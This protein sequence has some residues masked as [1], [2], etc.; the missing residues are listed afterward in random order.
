[1]NTRPPRRASPRS[2][3]FAAALL[4]LAGCGGVADADR[5]YEQ[6]QYAQAIDAYQAVYDEHRRDPQVNYRVG[7]SFYAMA[8][9]DKA[10]KFLR[11][12][13]EAGAKERDV[14]WRLAECQD[15]QKMYF[16]ASKTF[17]RILE[18]DPRSTAALNNLAVMQIQLDDYATAQGNLEKALSISPEDA[19]ALFNLGLVYERHHRDPEKAADYFARFRA[20][21]PDAAQA[22]EVR[23]WLRRYE[24]ERTAKRAASRPRPPDPVAVSPVDAPEP[25]ET[26]DPLDAVTAR[27][28]RRAAVF[29]TSAPPPPPRESPVFGT[30]GPAVRPDDPLSPEV[31]RGL[32][33]AEDYETVSR[34]FQ[35]EV[36]KNDPDYGRYAFYA[37]LAEL[38]KKNVPGA[39]TLLTEAAKR[40]PDEPDFLLQLGWAHHSAGDGEAA[41][42]LWEDGRSRFPERRDE[43]QRALEAL[44]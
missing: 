17:Q 10:E 40:H 43:F 29:D 30:G 42:K 18:T 24:T 44:P 35:E 25:P 39:V 38:E 28:A 7:R 32:V 27:P 15:R 11:R 1:M 16:D 21:A 34:R 22:G 23:D 5:L 6:K 33:D 12:A 26:G 4:A 36:R 14:F 20:R 3:P 2:L 8:R 19:E 31:F 37:G 13:V 9:Y 41:R